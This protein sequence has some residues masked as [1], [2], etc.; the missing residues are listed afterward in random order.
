MLSYCQKFVIGRFVFK[1]SIIARRGRALTGK[2]VTTT[3]SVG[4]VAEK[5]VARAAVGSIQNLKT[6]V[7]PLSYLNN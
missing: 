3:V 5:V 2:N 6:V 7:I 1:V 4:P